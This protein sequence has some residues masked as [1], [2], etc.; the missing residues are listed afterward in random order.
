MPANTLTHSASSHQLRKNSV[1]TAITTMPT[2]W[3]AVRRCSPRMNGCQMMNRPKCASMRARAHGSPAPRMADRC[4]TTSIVRNRMRQ[5]RVV[6]SC[7][8]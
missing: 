2:N 5:K 7:E 4:S 3:A 6:T 1:A 8:A